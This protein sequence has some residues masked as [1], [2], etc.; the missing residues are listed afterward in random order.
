MWAGKN[1]M[2]YLNSMVK[3]NIFQTF[4]I[5][6][7]CNAKERPKA[8]LY[9]DGPKRRCFGIFFVFSGIEPSKTSQRT[10]S[11]SHFPIV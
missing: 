3:T 7:F 10:P 9:A 6:Y 8:K 4:F 5:Y 11:G 1:Q 2:C